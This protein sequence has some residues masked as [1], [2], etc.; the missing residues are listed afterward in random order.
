MKLFLIIAVVALAA[1][2]VLAMRR[3]G[4]RITTIDRTRDADEDD[5]RS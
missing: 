4:P 2:V 3:T 1:I 5:D